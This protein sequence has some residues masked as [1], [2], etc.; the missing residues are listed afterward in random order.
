MRGFPNLRISR[1]PDVCIA[2]AVSKAELLRMA[3][4]PFCSPIA[5]SSC[6]FGNC[7]ERSGEQTDRKVKIFLFCFVEYKFNHLWK[8]SS[9]SRTCL[10]GVKRKAMC[11]YQLSWRCFCINLSVPHSTYSQKLTV[12]R[13]VS[14]PME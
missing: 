7:K 3:Y 8:Y 5:L 13:Y 2:S 11:N 12:N 9:G 6:V 4:G 10:L 1:F 14:F